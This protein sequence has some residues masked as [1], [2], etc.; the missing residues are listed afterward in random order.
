MVFAEV[1]GSLFCGREK[2]H[3][4]FGLR[5]I[6]TTESI[7]A[8]ALVGLFAGS[9][10]SVVGSGGLITFPLLVSIGLPPVTA[11]ITNNL[12]V[13]PGIVAATFSYRERLRG[14][15]AVLGPQLILAGLGGVL[16]GILL[17]AF[18]SEV[19]E[20]L[21]P[22]LMIFATSLILVGPAIKRTV[23][24]HTPPQLREKVI[25]L[26]A[27]TFLACIYGGYFGAGQGVLLLSYLTVL[28]RG[29]LHRANAYKNAIVTIS[30]STAAMMFLWLSSVDWSV[31]AV[32]ALSSS[33][34]GA[35]GGR[36]GQLIPESIYRGVMVTVGVVA[37][38]SFITR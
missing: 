29:S 21:V 36:Y 9:I 3:L 22:F 19:F 30:N 12:G 18:P 24:R 17:L 6:V 4:L 20:A 14:E 34:G 8:V 37:T 35:L 7:L 31:V 10:N 32:L 11:N 26:S 25:P 38:V 2:R 27:S 15:L 13:L 5:P 1:D 28:L 33:V 16:G 23:W